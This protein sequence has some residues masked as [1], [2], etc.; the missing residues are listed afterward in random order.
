MLVN[1]GCTVCQWYKLE[2]FATNASLVS[3]GRMKDGKRDRI[4]RSFHLLETWL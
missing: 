2:L 4:P 1:E 3:S